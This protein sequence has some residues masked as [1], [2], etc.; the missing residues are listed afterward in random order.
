MFGVTV[1]IDCCLFCTSLGILKVHVLV[2]ICV[3][4]YRRFEF[5]PGLDLGFSQSVAHSYE[6]GFESAVAVLLK[7]KNK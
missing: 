7:N 3:L 2:L 1:Y 4:C 5:D 6:F